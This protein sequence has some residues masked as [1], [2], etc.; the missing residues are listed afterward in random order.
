MLV[1]TIKQFGFRLCADPEEIPFQY[2]ANIQMKFEKDENFIDYAVVGYYIPPGES[3]AKLLNINDDGTF[4]LG[5]DCF[6]NRGTLSFSF[7]LVNSIEEVHLGSIDFD[8]RHAFGDS[9]SILPEP[10]ELWITLVTQVAKDAIKED[11]ALVQQKAKEASQS[12]LTASEKAN[13]TQEYANNAKVASNSA[14][15]AAGQAITAKNDAI[16]ASNQA[17]DFSNDASE[18]AIEA[19]NSADEALENANASNKA[20]ETVNQIKTQIEDKANEFDTNYQ[21]KLSAFND[22]ATEK[23]NAFNQSVTS[24]NDLFDKKVVEANND[25]DSKLQQ[26]NTTINEKVTEATNQANEAKKQAQIATDEVAKVPNLIEGKLDKN[27]GLENK[28]MVLVTD[29]EGNV[30]T[31]NKEDFE[32]GGTG[33]YNDLENKPTINGVELSGNKTS[34]DLKMYTQEEVNYLLNDKM[35]KPYYGITITDDTTIENTLA[36]NF[37]IDSIEGSI[38]QA[39]ESGIVPTPER[40]IPIRSKKITVNDEVIELRSLK[41]SK[42]LFDKNLLIA[43][44]SL[45]KDTPPILLKDKETYTIS[46]SKNGVEYILGVRAKQKSD[47]GDAEIKVLR[48]TTEQGSFTVDYTTYESYFVRIYQNA[49]DIIDTI[50]LELGSSA[51]SYVPPTVRDYKI[52]D[53]KTKTSKIVRNVK[54]IDLSSIGYQYQTGID[55]KPYR[56]ANYIYNLTSIQGSWKYIY[57]NSEKVYSYN[58]F[59]SQMENGLCVSEHGIMRVVNGVTNEDELKT[60]VD[61]NRVDILYAL[62][63]PTEESIPYLEDDTSDVGLSWQDSTSPSPDIKSEIYEVDEINIKTVGENI[64]T[65]DTNEWQIG[66]SISWGATQET[67]IQIINSNHMAIIKINNI[68]PSTLYSFK[69]ENTQLLWLDRIIEMNEKDLGVVNHK[70]YRDVSTDNKSEYS[71]TTNKNTNYI[72]IRV[73]T[74]PESGN[75]LSNPITDENILSNKI[76]FGQGT[77]SKYTPYQETSIQHTLSKPLRAT[78]DGSIKDIIDIIN[79]QTTHKLKKDIFDGSEDEMWERYTLSN[80]NGFGIYVKDIKVGSRLAGLCNIYKC[81]PSSSDRVWFTINNNLIYFPYIYEDLVINTLEDWR[82]WLSQN[83]VEVV[84]QLETPITE[85]LD[86]ELVQKLKTLKTFSPVTHVFV[87]GIAKP[88]LNAKYPK[89]IASAQAKLEQKVITLQEAVIK[90]V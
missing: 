5:P 26:A 20:I 22:N 74:L 54:N 53:H 32:G 49:T 36:G 24:A 73:R 67:P 45:N 58:G 30:I 60:Y 15:T 48:G 6:K 29:E 13:E 71:F 81:T 4:T 63:I 62:A 46:C 83:N 27:L 1:S 57:A 39:E 88:T 10:E 17:L 78:K 80:F 84:Y 87:T 77:I 65:N 41:E 38:Y 35:D 11:V 40:P 23:Q 14:T 59:Q 3:E 21:E 37:K 25:L 70:L 72:Y 43:I 34:S 82:S 44:S 42:N 68:K 8:V 89:D 2:S 28:N 79:N 76:S 47:G 52:V 86:D 75:G 66:K 16:A 9:S 64:L 18:S 12:A 50:Q 56:V 85:P 33:N 61:N 19:K 69:N 51:T 7:N 90:N 55:N 31:Q